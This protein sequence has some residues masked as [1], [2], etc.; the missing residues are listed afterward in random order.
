MS[1]LKQQ[2][3]RLGEQHP[4]L[5]THLREVLAGLEDTQRPQLQKASIVNTGIDDFNSRR[6]PKQSY[7]DPE[8]Q[9][10]SDALAAVEREN[11]IDGMVD[12][13]M[14]VYGTDSL[15]VTLAILLDES[16]KFRREFQVSVISR[17]DGM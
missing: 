12:A 1:N 17:V 10:V 6:Q 4:E 5:R 14:T 15:E 13:F 3:I 2:L 11:H 7:G 9:R 16:D 8:A